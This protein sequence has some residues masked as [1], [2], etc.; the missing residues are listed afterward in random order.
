MG[1]Y[2]DIPFP[3]VKD[4][5]DGHIHIHRWRD[6]KTGQSYIHGLEEYRQV[7]GLKYIALASLPSGN[8]IPA[9]R[10]VSN[11]IMCAFYKLAN[12]NT[13]A[14]GGFIYPSY[15]ANETEMTD[16]SLLTQLDE[17]NEI[18]FDGIKMLEGKPNLYAKVG[19]PLDSD[20][21]DAVL[22]KME[23]DGTYLLMHTADP[24]C[25]W[26]DANEEN[27]QKGWYYGD[28][29]KYPTYDDL[30]QQIDNI[31]AK[32]PRLDLCLA[33]FFFLSENP[34][35]LE[36][37]FER[38]ENLAVDITPGGEMYLG[39]NKRR[40]YYRSFFEKY[41]NRIYFGTD[42]DFT[43]HLEAGV[44]LCDRVYRYLASDEGVMSFDDTVLKGLNLSDE[45]VQN[46]FSDN[47]T[48]KLGKAPKPINKEALRKYIAKYRH[49]I[50]DKELDKYIDELSR[51]YLD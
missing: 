28:R 40:D 13:Y 38:Y 46:I 10:D 3:R 47:L 49:L 5:F 18:G 22:D 42:M 25:F 24:E 39:F 41:Q 31:L 35:K 50:A 30:Y 32:H 33:H 11:N 8:P 2:L 15:P 20:F 1:K 6:E 7:C 36:E 48:R 21:F 43:P 17:L 29:S 44:W 19:H 9:P 51:E 26:H 34:E 12:E 45:A 4:P 27:V 23:K 16:M 37:M 14:Y